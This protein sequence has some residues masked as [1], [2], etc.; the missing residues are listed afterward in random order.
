[1]ALAALGRL[2]Q[3]AAEFTAALALDPAS[4]LARDNLRR[5]QAALAKKASGRTAP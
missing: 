5:V 1:V 3:A 4:A 2:D